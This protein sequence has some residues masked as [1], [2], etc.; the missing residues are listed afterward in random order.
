MSLVEKALEKMQQAQRSR[1]PQAGAPQGPPVPN[2]PQGP[3][4]KVVP[5]AL[6]RHAEVGRAVPAPGRLVEINENALRAAGLLPPEHQARQ[7]GRQYRQIKRPLIAN[8]FGR[9]TAKVPNGHILMLASAMP[10]EGKTFTSINLA[11][12][13]ALER[14]I[15]VVLADADVPKPHISRLLG[16]DKEP[17]LLDVLR[18]P[19]RDIESVILP[20]NVPGF[21]ILPA[22]SRSENA[23]ELLASDR[24]REVVARMGTSDPNR[25]VIFDSPPL[26]L[27]S[28]SQALANVVGQIVVI[29]RADATPQ[30]TVLDALSHLGED[31]HVALV[32]N[33]SVTASPTNY[34]YYDNDGEASDNARST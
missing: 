1:A 34:Y 17:G 21:S 8:A 7:I 10:G 27:T 22:G 25:I 13:M 28:E 31:K 29:V 32:L 18:D 2:H 20:T 19:L 6:P 14:D 23:T 24:M 5:S 4:G 30:Q 9:G 26:L 3:F 15:H 16:V 11:F 12:S 33:Q